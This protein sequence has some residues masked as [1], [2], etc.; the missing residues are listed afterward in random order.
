MADDEMVCPSDGASDGE[1]HQS[2]FTQV[3]FHP[4]GDFIVLFQLMCNSLH[5]PSRLHLLALLSVQACML[6][7]LLQKP[8][9]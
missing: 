5:K 2:I 6:L 1:P 4:V 7:S 3:R 9:F 8:C